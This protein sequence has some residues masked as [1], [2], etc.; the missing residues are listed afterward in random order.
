LPVSSL[1]EH[2]CAQV[3]CDLAVT[4][5]AERSEVLQIA[6]TAAFGY[7]QDVVRVPQ[8]APIE[9][10]E[11]PESQH[12][13]TS[14]TARFFEAKKGAAGI[15]PADGADRFIPLEDELA[16]VAWIGAH[17]PFMDTPV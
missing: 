2:S 3:R 4:A 14:F 16:Y 8:A 6:F 15:E 5:E 10:V 12:L 7:R 9:F 17:A 11:S 1:R 13:F